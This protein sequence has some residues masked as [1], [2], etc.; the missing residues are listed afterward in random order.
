MTKQRRRT[1]DRRALKRRMP[2]FIMKTETS[3]STTFPQR[4][5]PV[6]A[7]AELVSSMRFAISLLSLLAIASIIGTVLKQGEPMTNYVNQFGPFWSDVF[8]KL[9]LYAVYSTGW[10]L[11]IMT[12]LVLSTS[13]CIIR[14]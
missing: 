1:V 4:E 2:P 6:V 3:F 12:F 7:F 10:F 13:L 14:N 5:H 9:G 11:V 8:G